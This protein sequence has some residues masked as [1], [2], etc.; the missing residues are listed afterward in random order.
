LSL[1]RREPLDVA[2]PVT[3]KNVIFLETAKEAFAVGGI[4]RARRAVLVA[5]GRA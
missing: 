4:Q 1:K 2:S 5:S 3:S